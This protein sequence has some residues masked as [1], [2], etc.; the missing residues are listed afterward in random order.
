MRM[1]A[2]ARRLRGEPGRPVLELEDV[3]KAYPGGVV[4]CRGVTL[5]LEGGR[6]LGLLGPNGAGKSTLSQLVAGLARPTSGHVRVLG[7]EVALGRPEVQGSIVYMAQDARTF[8]DLTPV[9]ALVAVARLRG[10][11]RRAARERA[12]VIA[13]RLRLGAVERRAIALLSGGERQRVALGAALMAPAPL[14]VL[15]EPT[16]SLDPAFRGTAWRLIREL[17]DAG[18]AVLLV[19]HLIAEAQ[20]VVDEV[21]VMVSGRVR[22]QGAVASVL[23]TADRRFRVRIRP[24]GLVPPAVVGAVRGQGAGNPGDAP[25][26]VAADRLPELFRW[27]GGQSDR[28]ERLDV[29]PPTLEEVAAQWFPAAP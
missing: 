11:G 23:A 16:A 21:A 26:L 20:A 2:T 13:H 24:E 9:E 3:Y 15:D 5:S 19:T 7:R 6:I 1:L 18:S 10:M 12:A 29:R 22:A 4:P 28:I 8:S 27:A 14:I 25:F 17:A